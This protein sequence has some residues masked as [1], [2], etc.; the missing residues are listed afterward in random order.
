MRLGEGSR[1][2]E[3]RAVKLAESPQAA[4]AKQAKL[5]KAAPMKLAHHR[6]PRSQRWL[7]CEGRV[8]EAGDMTE[9]RADEAGDVTEGRAG[10]ARAGATPLAPRKIRMVAEFEP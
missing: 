6:R 9:G 7:G 4:L 3:G 8:V 2:T 5:S 10:G 1:V